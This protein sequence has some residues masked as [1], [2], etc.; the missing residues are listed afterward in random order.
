MSTC[1]FY[2]CLAYVMY[3]IDHV[4]PFCSLLVG[5]GRD[6]G[7]RQREEKMSWRGGCKTVGAAEEKASKYCMEVKYK[8]I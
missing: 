8:V 2:L 1:L 5:E 7:R 6:R 3:L 4:E